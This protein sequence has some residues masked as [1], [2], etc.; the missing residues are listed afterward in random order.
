MTITGSTRR[1]R[2]AGASENAS[3][4]Q[5]PDPHPK[6]PEAKEPREIAADSRKPYSQP[7]NPP[8]EIRVGT[9]PAGS[10]GIVARYA[11]VAASIKRFARSC[12][13]RRRNDKGRCRTGGRGAEVGRWG[14]V[15]W[16]GRSCKGQQRQHNHESKC[17]SQLTT[18]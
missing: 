15:L 4:G 13:R 17:H 6:A 11:S 1:T 8:S 3:L 18:P 2:A 12:P 5:P 16:I 9:G 10:A 7:A 14:F